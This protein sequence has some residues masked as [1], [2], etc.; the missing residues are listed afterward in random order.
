MTDEQLRL[1]LGVEESTR[2]L[3]ANELQAQRAMFALAERFQG[4]VAAKLRELLG[5]PAYDQRIFNDAEKARR[6]DALMQCAYDGSIQSPRE[7]HSDW[8]RMHMEQGWMYGP[9]FDPVNKRHPNLRP[10]DELPLDARVKADIFCLVATF[11]ADMFSMAVEHLS[12][13]P[14]YMQLRVLARTPMDENDVPE[15]VLAE[16]LEAVG[17]LCDGDAAP[18][19]QVVVNNVKRHLAAVSSTDLIHDDDYVA[20]FE[21]ALQETTT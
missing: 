8:C 14:K 13:E 12:R 17:Q 19:V 5:E 21:Q 9:T 20:L 18:F 3:S 7:R 1:P 2:G 6:T 4:Y 15:E 10:W 16:R 11:T